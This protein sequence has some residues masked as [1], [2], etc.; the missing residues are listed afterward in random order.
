MNN[1]EP[2]INFKSLF[3]PFTTKKAIIIIFVVGL[4]VFLNTL[5]N[6]F[7]LDDNP[8]IIRNPNISSI[9]T[10][11]NLF[12]NQ[13]GGQETMN[14]YRPLPF[15]FY[16]LAH[17]I[18]SENP[19]PYHLIQLLFYITNAILVFLILRKFLNLKLAFFLSL[20]F[21]IHPINEEVAAYLA[22]LQD[23]LFLFFGLISLL[24]L[25]KNSKKT[26]YLLFANICLLLSIFSKETG[27][28]FFIIAFTYVYLFNKNRL[29]LHS[30]FSFLMGLAYIALRIASHTPLQKSAILPIM[31]LSFWQRM[32]NIPAIV[33]YYLQTFIFPKN[34]VVY[35]SWV[36]KNISFGS[37]FLPLFIDLIFLFIIFVFSFFVI[38]KAKK[39]TKIVIF[40]LIWFLLGIIAHSQI[41]LLDSTVADRF[42]YFPFV[43]LLALG[44]LF[45]QN[46]KFSKKLLIILSAVSICILIIFTIKTIVRNQNWQ[47]QS[48][49]LVHDEKTE[50]NNYLIELLYGNDL[51]KNGKNK[52]AILHI[53]KAIALYP[54]SSRAWTSLGSLYYSEGKIAPAKKAYIY[55]ISL[56]KDYFATYEN[57]GL[58]IKDHDSPAT[59]RDFLRK[60]TIMFPNSWKLWYYRFIVE[61]KLGNYNDSLLSAKNYFLL[62]QNAQSYNIYLYLLQ[63]RPIHIE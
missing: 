9:T 26:T 18:S 16:T 51:I 15:V 30:I 33:F 3:I 62:N 2:E 41:I 39:E 10:I 24:I 45:L 7:V 6:S 22:N 47:N 21:L 46:L 5:F 52:E 12:I 40:F 19:F 42:F 29:L 20:L 37:F 63:K 25:W 27:I 38:R 43:G 23:V 53:K 56:E 32:L 54:Q 28:L 11:P 8:Q 48:I 13:E 61:Y 55:S 58:L 31:Q 57:L 17:S 59:A 34:L 36:I 14:Y 1:K 50:G 35:H 4:I 49:L 60:A 44:G